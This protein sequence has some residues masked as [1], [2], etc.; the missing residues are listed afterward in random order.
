MN[1]L[2]LFTF[3][4]FLLLGNLVAQDDHILIPKKANPI[5]INNGPEDS[6]VL[7]FNSNNASEIL[8]VNKNGEWV[9]DARRITMVADLVSKKPIQVECVM[10]KGLFE[11]E[12][13]RVQK[14]EL[15]GVVT[16]SQEE[17]KKILQDLQNSRFSLN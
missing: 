7:V 17:F 12:N 3:C 5:I 8:V 15:S 2:L 16:A 1:K 4:G 9:S 13:P 6:V 10:W 11:P 14:W